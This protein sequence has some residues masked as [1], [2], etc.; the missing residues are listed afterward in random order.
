MFACEQYWRYYKMYE[1]SDEKNIYN[2][3][4]RGLCADF[5]RRGICKR[6]D[7]AADYT[8]LR[9]VRRFKQDR[10]YPEESKRR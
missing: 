3:F 8:G 2:T 10:F 5:L 4:S 1:V 9:R 6:T 7:C